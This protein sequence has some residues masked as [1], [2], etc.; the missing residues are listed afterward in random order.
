MVNKPRRRADLSRNF[1]RNANLSAS[2]DDG[3]VVAAPPRPWPSASGSVRT[4]VAARPATTARH[5]SS[6]PAR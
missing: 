2:M 6:F 3:T 5:H 1:R 4:P